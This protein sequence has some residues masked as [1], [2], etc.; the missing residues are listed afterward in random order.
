[1][2]VMKPKTMDEGQGA[3]DRFTEG[4]KALFRVPKSAVQ[5]NTRRASKPKRK[6]KVSSPPV[7]QS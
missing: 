7:P 2:N 1:M 5:E 4:M 3:L 6:K